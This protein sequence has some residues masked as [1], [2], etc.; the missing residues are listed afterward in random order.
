M[1][2]KAGLEKQRKVAAIL[3]DG[4]WHTVAEIARATGL[5]GETVDVMDKME[6]SGSAE[7][8]FIRGLIRYRD[9]VVA[10]GLKPAEPDVLVERK[11]PGPKPKAKPAAKPEPRPEPVQSVQAAPPRAADEAE[12][13]KPIAVPFLP[14][15]ANANERT[16][17]ERPVKIGGFSDGS[18][19]ISRNYGR[20]EISLTREEA[21]EVVGFIQRFINM[22]AA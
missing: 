8:G 7:S 16:F 15:A 21:L 4:A 11:K 6:E 10:V 20:A 5:I 2:S 12:D 14:I 19:I 1:S 18:F 22:E 13:D 17:K 9:P 3:A